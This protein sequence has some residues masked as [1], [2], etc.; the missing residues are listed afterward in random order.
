MSSDLETSH[1]TTQRHSAKTRHKTHHLTPWQL[2]TDTETAPQRQTPR[3]K[4]LLFCDP[5]L[6]IFF[7]DRAAD[8]RKHSAKMRE[9]E[10]W[11]TCI[12][13]KCTLPIGKKHI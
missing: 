13:A 2:S 5:W 8:G 6:I 7:D 3:G 11:K 10:I 4:T 9:L 1:R 12:L